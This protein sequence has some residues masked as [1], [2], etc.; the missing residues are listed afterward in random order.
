MRFELITQVGHNANSSVYK[1]RDLQT[2]AIVAV[3]QLPK[4]LELPGR[5]VFLAWQVTHKNVCRIHDLHNEDGRILI[6]MEYL[7]GESLR[8]RITRAKTLP[9]DE[10]LQIAHQMM[11][12][13]EEAHRH[14]II[15]RD[16]KPENVLIQPD[17]TIKLMDFGIA[18][19]AARPRGPTRTSNLEGTPIYVAPEAVFCLQFDARTDIYA[20]GIILYELISGETPSREEPIEFSPSVPEH[21][22]SAILRC[23]KQDPNDRFASI[24]EMRAALMQTEPRPHTFRHPGGYRPPLQLRP[25]LLLCLLLT[26]SAAILL[27]NSGLPVTQQGTTKQPVVLA[28]DSP[29]LPVVAVLMQGAAG[30]AIR[31]HFIRGK[32]FRVVERSPVEQVLSELRMS[33]TQSFSPV[34]AERMGHLVGAQYL[35]LGS[36]LTFDGQ[37]QISARL[38]R[39]ETGEVVFAENRLGRPG[40][41]VSLAETIAAH[42]EDK[43]PWNR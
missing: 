11:D 40:D 32:K 9:L 41:V 17:G 30:D 38:V 28:P 15:H 23:T 10:C 22:Q 2:K 39:V 43:E 34:V 42:C 36:S 25:F 26:I 21:I 13:L 33:N 19:M 20:L 12:G 7:E 14:N 3:K 27:M 29:R 6:S 5:E 16:L 24:A 31:A 37:I 35:L 1:A 4:D 8:A 18:R